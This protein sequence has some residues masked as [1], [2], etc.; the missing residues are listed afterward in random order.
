MAIKEF[1]YT[2]KPLLENQEILAKAGSPVFV[3]GDFECRAEGAT[4]I[5]RPLREFASIEEARAALE[6]LLRDYEAE[7]D[8][9]GLP[10]SF[11]F[12]HGRVSQASEG[13]DRS[14]QVV[15][16]NQAV[17]MSSALSLKATVS[18][19]GPSG[20]FKSTPVVDYL[21][22]RWLSSTSPYH[23]VA[24]SAAYALKTF[25]DS[26]YGN[27]DRAAKT[28]LISRNVLA[29][30]GRLSSKHDRYQGRK[31]DGAEDPLTPDE[32]GWLKT[33]IQVV[34]RRAASVESGHTPVDQITLAHPDFPSLP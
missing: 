29:T 15:V 13:G 28:L 3:L 7:L 9:H 22:H 1:T 19:A 20:E 4:L 8:L 33:F 17:E 32:I 18:F 24:A 2:I 11:R 12:S 25:L 34:G 26:H 5:A 27:P 31:M 23:E 30:A 21:R 6:P 14:H 10:T 16:V